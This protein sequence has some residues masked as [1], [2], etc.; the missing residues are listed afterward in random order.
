MKFIREGCGRCFQQRKLGKAAA[1]SVQ[2]IP[3][4]VV[5]GLALR[6]TRFYR[7]QTE[8]RVG[9]WIPGKTRGEG[10]GETVVEVLYTLERCNGNA[11]YSQ[12]GFVL[13]EDIEPSNLEARI[14]VWDRNLN[15]RESY[16]PQYR[17]GQNG[18]P[19]SH[20]WC[21]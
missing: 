19:G 21:K 2:I 11:D 3:A 8:P 15:Q 7:E 6:R 1:V 16:G 13:F 17:R 18:S 20:C 5:L 10:Q 9:D 4:L 14:S 12:A